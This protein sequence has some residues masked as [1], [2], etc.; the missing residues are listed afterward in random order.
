M[1]RVSKYLLEKKIKDID[2]MKKIEMLMLEESAYRQLLNADTCVSSIIHDEI[3]NRLKRAFNDRKRL[4]ETFFSYEIAMDK[5]YQI[6][7]DINFFNNTITANTG[8]EEIMKKLCD[9]GFVLIH[10]NKE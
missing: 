1:L 6:I 4:C 9:I 8:D 3:I 10:P 5:S 2:T 7:L